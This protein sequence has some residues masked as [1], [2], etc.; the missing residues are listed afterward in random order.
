MRFPLS[1]AGSPTPRAA[2]SQAIATDVL[3]FTAGF[4]PHDP[5]TGR[6][7][8]G[9]IQAQT[10]QTLSNI[11]AILEADG[12]G[13]GDIVKVTVHLA[14]LRR[15]FTAFDA[16]YRELIPAPYPVRTTVGSQLMDIL[17]EM[18][19]VAV[20]GTDR[21]RG[22]RRHQMSNSVER[23]RQLSTALVSDALD[24]LGRRNQNMLPDI[25]RLAGPQRIAGTA[26]TLR[27]V[28]AHE[29]PM[30]PYKVQFDAI[31]GLE[32]NQIL[33][34]AA[35]DV[36]SAFWGELITSRARRRGAVGAVVDGYCRDLSQIRDRN[37]FGVW[38]RGT[39]PA[40]SL[41]RLDAVDWNAPVICRGVEVRPRDFVL[42]DIDGVVVVPADL[43][44]PALGLAEDKKRTEDQV[45]KD[46]GSG[47]SI[48]DAY[49]RFGVM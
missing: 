49:E 13:F 30:A 32:E 7:V 34:V 12:L 18:D 1:S 6:I 14:D 43:I 25:H 42:C 17:V 39:H 9:E 27:A 48:G 35:P 16:T 29:M 24:A 8:G 45:R 46:L 19:V 33:V 47:S 38:A 15:D 2:Y 5:V 28:E 20:R 36:A 41:G 26:S 3:V 11:E 31:D 21:N 23:L 4:G 40:D 44:E 10:R 37:D 22:S